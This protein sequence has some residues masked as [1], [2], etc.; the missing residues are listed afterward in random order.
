M[1]TDSTIRTSFDG[2]RT[3]EFPP[4]ESVAVERLDE[5]LHFGRAWHRYRYCYP[6]PEPSML[7][8]LDAA[9]GTGR[10]TAEAA[11]L[12]PQAHVLGIDASSAALP[13]ARER[14]E[15]LGLLE[16]VAF[17][18]HDPARPLPETLGRFD[19][20]I[21]RGGLAGVDDP[22][23]VLKGLAEALDP[24]GLLYL[25]LPSRVGRAASRSLRQAIDAI[26]PATSG[27]LEEERYRVGLEVVL[28]LHADHPIRVR[29]T[30][31]GLEGDLERFVA[32]CLSDSLDWSYDEAKCLLEE[33]G[34]RLLYLATPWRWRPD[35][36]FSAGTLS[37]SVRD[38]IERLDP[39][40][41]GR[42]IDAL[43]S[44]LLSSEFPLYACHQRF[45]PRIPSWVTS[46]ADDPEIFDRLVPHLTGLMTPLAGGQGNSGG[47]LIYRTVSGAFGELDRWSSLLLGAVDGAKTCGEI[48]KSLARRTRAS[49]E[50]TT[51]H[52]RWIDLA[53]GGLVFLEELP[54]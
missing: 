45:I 5:N 15:S 32:D 21:C 52:E 29:V 40:A 35:R 25:T 17:L 19:F 23:R 51:R 9:C 20:V 28:S 44:S 3:T 46:R 24:A 18:E 26:V 31:L 36:V 54:S 33:A 41:V 16:N 6:R 13:F 42:L 4:A 7:R 49:D 48:E 8:I 50:P 12:N 53:D 14:A 1:Q 11:Q 22:A 2:M 30:E 43:D 39:E 37:D 27:A 34:L 10:A 38:R 47:R